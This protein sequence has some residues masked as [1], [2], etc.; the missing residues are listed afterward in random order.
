MHCREGD[1]RLQRAVRSVLDQSGVDLELI[2]VDDASPAGLREPLASVEDPRLRV[3]CHA[4]NRGAAAAR[5]TGVA[6]ARAPVVAFLDADDEWLP[7]MA[8]AQLEA[9][10][11]APRAAGCTTG[12]FLHRPRMPHEVRVPQPDRPLEERAVLGCDL[13]PGSTLAIRREVWQAVGGLDEALVRLEDWDLLLRLAPAHELVVIQQPLV[14]V[15]LDGPGPRPEVVAAATTRILGRH[16]PRL[17]GWP[18]RSRRLRASA[19]YEVG[20]AALRHG[21]L[22]DAAIELGRALWLDPCGRVATG[23]WAL[24]TRGLGRAGATASYLPGQGVGEG[25][26]LKV[27]EPSGQEEGHGGDHGCV[28]GG[29]EAQHG[30]RA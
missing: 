11:C 13:S 3:Q 20:L 22:E 14:R 21:R 9:L 25:C 29:P 28:G 7:G 10:C 12:F 16:L 27:D 8:Q 6:A 5:N 19:H 17:A 4:T 18:R 2:V 24:A 1:G 23:A 30:Q 15:H 26:P